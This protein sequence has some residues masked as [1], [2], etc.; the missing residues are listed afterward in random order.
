MV[1]AD[2]ELPEIGSNVQARDSYG[3]TPLHLASE[4][5]QDT[6]VQRRLRMG[7]QCCL[8]NPLQPPLP[9]S[10]SSSSFGVNTA[11]KGQ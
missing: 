7:D 10:S 9:S 3:L 11:L 4:N 2:A 6:V 5:G 8:L 1:E